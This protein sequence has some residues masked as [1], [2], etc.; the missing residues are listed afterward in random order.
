MKTINNTTFF[1][2]G[3]LSQ[4]FGGFKNQNSDFYYNGKKYNCAEQWMMAQKACLFQDF[5]SE[6]KIR[7]T[8]NPREQQKIGRSV[9]NYSQSIWD[10]HKEQIVFY[11]NLLKFSQNPHL[12]KILINCG[13]ELVEASPIDKVWGIGIG[14]DNI[15]EEHCDS[16]NWGGQNLLG[17][18]LTKV[19]SSL[20]Y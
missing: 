5:E 2:K 9:K 8:E 10:A 15:T 20:K 17:K 4:W 18:V 12:R 13:D 19:K 11:G 7:A 1:Y 16:K 14:M 6:T 3:E